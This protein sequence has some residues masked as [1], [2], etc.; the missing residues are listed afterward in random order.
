[1]PDSRPAQTHLGRRIGCVE[2]EALYHYNVRVACPAW[3]KGRIF[4]GHQLWWLF[5]RRRS[6]DGLNHLPKRFWCSHCWI[7]DRRKVKPTTVAL[8]QNDPTGEREWKRVVSCYRSCCL[9]SK[10]GNCL[11]NLHLNAG[12]PEWK[13]TDPHDTLS[14][15][16][17]RLHKR[18]RH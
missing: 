13:S 6:N 12:Q 9:I 10:D 2:H 17:G 1:M 18:G 11:A 3:R 5:H 16:F 7:A 15:K 4:E 14:L 8:T